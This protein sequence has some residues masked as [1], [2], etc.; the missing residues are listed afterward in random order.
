V[1]GEQDAHLMAG[2]SLSVQ[3]L[4]RITFTKHKDKA[5]CTN[6]VAQEEHLLPTLQY[7]A[8]NVILIYK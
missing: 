6:A 3:V 7:K 2:E 4:F 1:K 5:K 8:T